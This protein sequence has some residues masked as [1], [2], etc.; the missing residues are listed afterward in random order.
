MTGHVD[1]GGLLGVLGVLRP[2]LLRHERPQQVDGGL[3]LCQH[4]G[5]HVE[6]LSGISLSFCWRKK[7]NTVK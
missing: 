3:V 7:Q 4:V 5:V 1:D 2:R 6:V